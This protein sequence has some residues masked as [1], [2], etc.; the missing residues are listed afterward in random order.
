MMVGSREVADSRVAIRG[1]TRSSNARVAW[2]DGSNNSRW[3]EGLNVENEMGGN[4]RNPATDRM[5]V[6]NRLN[7]GRHLEGGMGEED[8]AL[9]Q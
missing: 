3:V 7:R 2:G 6:S 1:A 9:M 5:M 4:K 8:M